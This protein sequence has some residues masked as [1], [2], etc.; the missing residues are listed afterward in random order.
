MKIPTARIFM[1]TNTMMIR[2]LILS[3]SLIMVS[4]HNS[5][6]IATEAK[7]VQ[8][9]SP[10]SSE[11]LLMSTLWF[12]RSLEA[13]LLYLQGYEFARIKMEKN[14][15][16]TRNGNLA[17]ITD[18]DET[19]LDN[20]PYEASLIINNENYSPDTWKQWVQK[21]DAKPLPGALEFLQFAESRGVEIF[22]ISNRNIENIA[23]TIENLEK[24][25]FPFADE[26]HVYLKDGNSDKS[27]RR[28]RVMD[29]YEIVLFIGDQL[30]DFS[31]E[32]E[33]QDREAFKEI[34]LQ[35][36]R[37]D[38]EYSLKQHFILLPN[39]MYGSFESTIYPAKELSDEEKRDIRL[40][41]LK[42]AE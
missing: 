23:A 16:N 34:I 24:Y 18:I 21:A 14:I 39:P 42:P 28:Q 31:Q 40:G 1:P 37:G 12:Q 6:S 32:Y 36:N 20:S 35:E 8:T 22:Y 19:I 26:E 15:E 13:Q 30:G 5:K 41:S 11:H 29:G 3:I 2:I 33:G 27:E 7:S 4:C 25:N 17:I 9:S 38:R 10:S